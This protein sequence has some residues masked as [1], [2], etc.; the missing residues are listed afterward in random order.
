M[1]QGQSH[2]GLVGDE[3]PVAAEA[4]G[5]PP[6]IGLLHE[7]AADFGDEGSQIELRGDQ[8]AHAEQGSQVLDVTF[9]PFGHSRELNL[10]GEFTAVPRPRPVDLA[11]RGR[12][13]WGL[14]EPRESVLPI[15]AVLPLEDTAK[16]P[17]GHGVR[18]CAEDGERLREGGGENR[19]TLE[20]NQLSEFHG[21]A[22]HAR[23]TV[24][25]G[26]R[27]VRSKEQFLQLRDLSGSQLSSAPEQGGGS[28]ATGG[29]ANVEEAFYPGRGNPTRASMRFHLFRCTAHQSDSIPDRL[30]E[31]RGIG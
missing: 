16:L 6:V 27:V 21:R 23:E 26:H 31:D 15:A 8:A 11:D 1:G 14:V 2:P 10:E 13:H 19:A 29:N 25:Q 17:V 4:L 30:A 18:R 5:L 24:G 12:S 20:R 3:A 28:H 22:A 7:L 9:D